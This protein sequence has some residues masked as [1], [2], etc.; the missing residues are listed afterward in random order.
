MNHSGYGPASSDKSILTKR[1]NI[2][3]LEA[4]S[5]TLPFGSTLELSNVF[6]SP[7]PPKLWKRAW[8][9]FQ[10]LSS[11]IFCPC[12][13]LLGR[14]S[15]GWPMMKCPGVRFLPLSSCLIG[16]RAQW[17]AVETGLHLAQDSCKFLKGQ[18]GLSHYLDL[19]ESPRDTVC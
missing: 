16:D 14:G 17:T 15:K 2:I 18:F 9:R 12:V 19:S 10:R 11:E 7:P 4:L 6:R 5:W 8:H 13:S 1:D 3:N